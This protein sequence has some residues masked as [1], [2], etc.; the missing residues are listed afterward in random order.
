MPQ[1]KTV[2]FDHLLP[3]YLV[4]DQNGVSTE[5]LYDLGALFRSIAANSL[6]KTQKRVFGDIH[7]FHAC[8]FDE[9]LKIW[10]L[11]ILHLRE[12][13][14][15]GIA[16]TEGAYELI[17]L[18]NGK[19]PAEST[20]VLYDD[21]HHMLYMQRNIFGTSIRALEIY[22]QELSPENISVVLKPKMQNNR[23]S[24]I[25]STNLY[26]RVILT[27]DAEQLDERYNGSSLHKLLKTFGEYQ[28]RIVK[29]DLGFGHQ[30]NGLLQSDAT[31]KLVKEAYAFNGIQKLE[32]RTSDPQDISFETIDLLDDRANYKIDFEYSRDNPITHNRMFYSCSSEYKR[33]FGIE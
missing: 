1:K 17:Q 18:E 24:R 6:Q 8:Q 10:E 14:L 9:K 16:D 19:Y 25:V 13:I 31:T 4:E 33:E 3:Y 30:R 2:Q 15:P 28:G 22:L 23:L 29:L 11:Q 5:H 21:I 26:R 7:L 27:A 32:V 12:K 20:T